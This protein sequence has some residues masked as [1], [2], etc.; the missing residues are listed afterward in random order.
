M[1]YLG[2]ADF[3]TGNSYDIRILI[4]AA[5]D[6]ILYKKRSKKNGP[7]PSCFF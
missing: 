5:W 2:S 1:P 6:V 4:N 7:F 3:H